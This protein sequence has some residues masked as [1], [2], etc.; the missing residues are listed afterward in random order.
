MRHASPSTL[1]PNRFSQHSC[2]SLD[3]NAYVPNALG[4]TLRSSLS[5]RVGFDELRRFAEHTMMDQY[6]RTLPS[7]RASLFNQRTALI[8]GDALQA[9]ESRSFATNH[10]SSFCASL[11]KTIEQMFGGIP[12]V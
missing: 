2:C 4:W 12:D 3:T 5:G 11:S 6:R 9:P 7:I 8:A 1:P 10:L